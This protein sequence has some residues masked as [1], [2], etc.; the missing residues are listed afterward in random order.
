M[1]NIIV[2]EK[3]TL[4]A[5]RYSYELFLNSKTKD[6]DGNEKEYLK[7]LGSYPTIEI[8]LRKLVRLQALEDDSDIDLISYIDLLNDGYK[9]LS[10]SLKGW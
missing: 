5:E 8:A 10:D 6:K 3:Y 2:N 7:F 4:R 1:R 9:L